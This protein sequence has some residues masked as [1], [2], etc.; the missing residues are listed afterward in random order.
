MKT[1]TMKSGPHRAGND[2][3]HTD[4]AARRKDLERAL[5]AIECSYLASA[6]SISELSDKVLKAAK[7]FT[8]SSYGFASYIDQRTG[9]LVNPM[10]KKARKGHPAAGKPLVFREFTG[11]WGWAL[12]NRKPLLTNS[13]ASDPR[14]AGTPRGHIKIKKFMAAPA[15]LNREL[16]G[17]IA[18]ANPGRD[19]GPRDLAALKKLA[20]VYAIIIQRKLAEDRLKENENKYR[21]LVENPGKEYFFYQT[22]TEGVLTFVSRTVTEMLGYSQNEFCTH[23][24]RRLTKN[25][26]N[27]AAV[28]QTERS[29]RG[30]ASP[31]YEAEVRH[32][33]GSTRWLELTGASLRDSAGNVTGIEGIAHDITKHKQTEQGM[34]E[35]KALIAAVVENV[36]LMIFLKEAKHLRFVIMNRAGEELLGYNRR[37]LLGNND[38]DL[39]PPEQAAHFTARDREVLDAETGFL[40]IP[41]EPIMTAGKGTRLLHTRKVCIRGAD[42]TT[43]YLLGISEDITERK[44]LEEE[45]IR[46]KAIEAVTSVARPAAHDF[47]NILAAISG[48]ATLMMENLKAGNPAKPE[49]EQI[50]SA[51]KRAAAITTR[52]QTYGSDTGKK[53]GH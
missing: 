32:K 39:F 20:R 14:S 30:T 33:D 37:D 49:I 50:I 44:K 27:K 23:Y 45:L 13:A 7:A 6:F 8:G 52:L 35:S 25:P 19:Y 12:K 38:F 46:I 51:V 53:P 4:E 5:D 29:L 11:L 15:I 21:R 18:L 31:S 28:R 9:W 22:D 2:S 24:T 3:A 1:E 40:D 48:Y 26:V 43:K 16:A 42:G 34:R 41:E 36:P 17:I 47:N 10:A